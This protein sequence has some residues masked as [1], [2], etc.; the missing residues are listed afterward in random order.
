MTKMA[1]SNL[2][3]VTRMMYLTDILISQV[4]EQAQE[5]Y[6]GIYIRLAPTIICNFRLQTEEIIIYHKINEG[7]QQQN[8]L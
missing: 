4:T 7:L 2:N 5:W 1:N 6:W 8:F 3:A